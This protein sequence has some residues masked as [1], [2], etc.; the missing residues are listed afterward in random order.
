MA[1]ASR[2]SLQMAYLKSLIVLDLYSANSHSTTVAKNAY[3]RLPCGLRDMIYEG[4]WSIFDLPK[5]RGKR[6]TIK[7]FQHAAFHSFALPHIIAKHFARE[8]WQ[9]LYERGTVGRTIRLP[10]LLS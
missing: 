3:E 4:L 10:H 8:A 7:K 5:I 6:Y 2:E 1:V 9:W